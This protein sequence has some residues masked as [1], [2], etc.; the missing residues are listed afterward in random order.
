MPI[1]GACSCSSLRGELRQDAPLQQL[2]ISIGNYTGPGRYTIDAST[3]RFSL[4]SK[5]LASVN[6]GGELVIAPDGS[7]S[8]RA[9]GPFEGAGD[10][11]LDLTFA[12]VANS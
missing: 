7:G 2:A 1:S 10:V 9:A 12:C 3:L 6:P 5:Q 4:R 11:R 8:M